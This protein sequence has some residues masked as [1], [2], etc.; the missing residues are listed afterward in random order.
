MEQVIYLKLIISSEGQFPPRPLLMIVKLD[1]IMA[2]L[3][4][5]IS[6]ANLIANN[7]T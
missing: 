3:P 4:L 2:L 1:K 7:A 6:R 5:H